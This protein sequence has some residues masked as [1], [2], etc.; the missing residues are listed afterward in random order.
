MQHFRREESR[1]KGGDWW[2]KP[3]EDKNADYIYKKIYMQ[4]TFIPIILL[5]SFQN[6]L[7]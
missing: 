7:L 3:E 5:L 4:N 1:G 6:V 2:P